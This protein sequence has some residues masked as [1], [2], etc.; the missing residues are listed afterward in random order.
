MIDDPTQFSNHTMW[1]NSRVNVL[2]TETPN[3]AIAQVILQLP[4]SYTVREEV[5]V[6]VAL[7]FLPLQWLRELERL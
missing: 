1:S 5:H 3:H 2:A 4:L 6:S 7:V